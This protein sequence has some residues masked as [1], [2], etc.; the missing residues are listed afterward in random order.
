VEDSYVRVNITGRPDREIYRDRN[1]LT[2]ELM[3][4]RAG[5]SPNE[6]HRPITAIDAIEQSQDGFA[7]LGSP[8]SGKTTAFRHIAV[9]IA[10]GTPLRGRTRLPLYLAV[11]D[12][13][14]STETIIEAAR[15]FFLFLRVTEPNRVVDALLYSGD[16]IVLVD[17]L[18]ETTAEHQRLLIGELAELQAH[19]SNV[20]FCV[21]ARPHSLS[22]GLPLFTKWET[23]PLNMEERIEFTKNGSTV[24]MKKRGNDS[25]KIVPTLRAF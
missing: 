12:M 15:Q 2:F 25:W 23:L 14:K 5:V 3:K 10:R 8:G 1:V 17:G 21:S 22:K 24:L 7:L 9:H 20:I 16:V 11:R 13:E 6:S 18:D 19:Y 4:E